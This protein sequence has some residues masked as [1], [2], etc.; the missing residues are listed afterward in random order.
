[1]STQV[2]WAIDLFTAAEELGYA[3]MSMTPTEITLATHTKSAVLTI[4]G[5]RVTGD[6][7]R[8]VLKPVP[9]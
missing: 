8:A 9:A 7:L 3:V 6:L 1:M 5:A 2:D 4:T